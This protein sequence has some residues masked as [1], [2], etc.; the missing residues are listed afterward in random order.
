MQSGF[1]RSPGILGLFIASSSLVAVRS[2]QAQ[3]AAQN[4]GDFSQQL[5]PSKKLPTDVI[6]VKGAWSSASDSV[7]PVPEGEK[8][9]NGFYSNPY[10]GLDYALSPDWTRKYDGPP[11]SDS[12]YYVLAQIQP[13]DTFKWTIRGSILIAAQDLFF[14]F[15]PARNA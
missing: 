2:G 9:S 7:T 1:S 14:T 11:P 12:G 13:A 6:L 10:F 4:G 15:T 8:V 3:D 5:H